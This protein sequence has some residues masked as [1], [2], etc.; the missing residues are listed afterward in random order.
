MLY[1]AKQRRTSSFIS[2][3]PQ[4]I[5]FGAMVLFQNVV[6]KDFKVF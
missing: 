6:Y 5:T 1:F 3:G 4:C 2:I